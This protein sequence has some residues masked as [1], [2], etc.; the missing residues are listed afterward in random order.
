MIKGHEIYWLIGY[1]TITRTITDHYDS[2]E[3][4]FVSNA[5]L[6]ALTGWFI[7]AKSNPSIRNKI[8]LSGVLALAACQIYNR[9]SMH[10]DPLFEIRYLDRWMAVI[11]VA[12]I[13]Y[14]I[15]NKYR[16][17]TRKANE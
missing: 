8:A 1:H 3:M 4:Y 9:V 13:G 16:N 6:I 17:K 15:I 2:D 10:I 12:D 14:L 5:V 7:Y 11:V